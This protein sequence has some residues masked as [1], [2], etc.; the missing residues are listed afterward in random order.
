[1]RG[2]TRNDVQASITAAPAPFVPTTRSSSRSP[3][4][5]SRSFFSR[6]CRNLRAVREQ[7]PAQQSVPEPN[8]FA[9]FF[10]HFADAAKNVEASGFTKG[11]PAAAVTL[12]LDRDSEGLRAVCRAVFTGWQDIIAAGLDEVPKAKRREIAELILATLEGPPE[13][14]TAGFKSRRQTG[15]FAGSWLPLVPVAKA[16]EREK[17]KTS[18]RASARG[19]ALVARSPSRFGFRPRLPGRTRCPS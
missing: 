13:Y 18:G 6:C 2:N 3:E 16:Q 11:C 1:M 19:A 8:S 4:K 14:L 7:C 17:A 5:R 10:Y 9:C 12:D 15:F